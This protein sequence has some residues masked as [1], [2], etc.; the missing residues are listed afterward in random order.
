MTGEYPGK[1]ALGVPVPAGCR[2]WLGSLVVA[3]WLGGCLVRA[4]DVTFDMLDLS[5]DQADA[6]IM[7][8][9]QTSAAGRAGATDPAGAT[10]LQAAPSASGTPYE[11]EIVAPDPIQP[12]GPPCG[13]FFRAPACGPALAPRPDTGAALWLRHPISIGWMAGLMTGS[14]LEDDWVGQKSGFVGEFWFGWDVHPKWGW[15]TRLAVASIELY[16]S[17]RA[18]LAQYQMDDENDIPANDPYRRRF[19]R[20]READCLF[21]DVRFLWYPYTDER[22][23]TYLAAGVGVSSA[24]YIDRLDRTYSDEF[25]SL[26][27]ALGV[28]CRLNRLIALRLEC[29]NRLSLGGDVDVLDD[30][31]LTA[32]FEFRLGGERTSYWP[33][34]PGLH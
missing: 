10:V 5:W 33:W 9:S 3:L 6:P 22:W 34:N 29:S 13:G 26:P 2:A 15:E 1:V 16:D 23:R 31:S 20:H 25:V 24:E 32:G 21:W 19:Q 8:L 17:E 28:K 4:D 18:K 14:A 30:F 11:Y 12:A 7:F 27:V